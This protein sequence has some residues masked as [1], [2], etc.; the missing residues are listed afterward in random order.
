M[1]VSVT[2]GDTVWLKTE[3]KD[4]NEALADPDVGTITLKIYTAGK[5]LLTTLTDITKTD[6]GKY[7]CPYLIPVGTSVLYFEYSGTVGSHVETKRETL[8]REW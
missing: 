2:I 5:S 7:E 8:I 6:T 1:S 4:R 3:F